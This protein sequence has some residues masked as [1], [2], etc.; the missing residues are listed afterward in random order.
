MRASA[1]PTLARLSADS[2]AITSVA[3]A[4]QTSFEKIVIAIEIVWLICV[5]SSFDA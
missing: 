5:A 3:K 4:A 1:E 2:P